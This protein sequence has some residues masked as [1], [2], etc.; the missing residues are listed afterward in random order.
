MG[1]FEILSRCATYTPSKRLQLGYLK[2]IA[3]LENVVCENFPKSFPTKFSHKKTEFEN[4]QIELTQLWLQKLQIDCFSLGM[5]ST[6][7]FP[8]PPAFY[9]F[10]GLSD[11]SGGAAAAG[12]DSIRCHPSAVSLAPPAVPDVFQ[13]FGEQYTKADPPCVILSYEEKYK[14]NKS[15]N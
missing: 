6:Q 2:E 14:H 9:K 15:T 4:L 11:A 7:S 8:E 5:K 3:A 10:Y 1:K 13:C 12:S